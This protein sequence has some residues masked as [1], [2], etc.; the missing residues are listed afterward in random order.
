MNFIVELNMLLY[1]KSI[2]CCWSKSFIGPW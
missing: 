2:N 1:I